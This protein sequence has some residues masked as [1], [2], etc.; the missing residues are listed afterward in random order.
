MSLDVCRFDGSAEIV[1]SACLTSGVRRVVQILH[2]DWPAAFLIVAAAGWFM[3]FFVAHRDLI[4]GT[5]VLGPVRRGREGLVYADFFS[6][7]AGVA[8]GELAWIARSPGDVGRPCWAGVVLEGER[9]IVVEADTAQ[10][11]R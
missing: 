1:G 5:D 4:A 11:Y 9:P 7:A 8:C 10:T 6:E 2:G 3:A